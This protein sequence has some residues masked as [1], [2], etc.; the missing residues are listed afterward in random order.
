MTKLQT[1]IDLMIQEFLAKVPADVAGKLDA[2]VE[3]LMGSGLAEGA[4]GVG[5]KVPDVTMPNAMG[6]PVSLYEKLKDGPVVL[7]FYRGSW[8]SFCDLQLRAYGAMVPVL[9]EMGVQLI[10]VSPEQLPE[11]PDESLSIKQK[12]ALGFEVLS[13]YHNQT[14]R[15]LGLVYQVDEELREIYRGFGFDLEKI[16]QDTSWSLPLT[17][18]FVIDE[19]GEI[20]WSYVNADYRKRAEPSDI[21]DAVCDL[22]AVG[23]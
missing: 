6:Q 10:A 9:K 11:A 1:A 14:A 19:S 13:D 3:R 15:R 20:V 12:A 17:G 21:V 23:V 7:T 8:C 5:R 16:N 4:F 22:V 18:T 2:G